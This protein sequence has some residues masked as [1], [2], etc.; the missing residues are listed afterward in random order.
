[1]SWTLGTTESRAPHP[2]FFARMERVAWK[3][4]DGVA[5]RVP[6]AQILTELGKL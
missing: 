6:T 4:I 2:M 3:S 5:V 1:M